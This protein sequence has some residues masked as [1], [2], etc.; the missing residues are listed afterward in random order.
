[1]RDSLKYFGLFSHVGFVVV[2]SILVFVWLGVW[3]DGKVSGSKGAFTVAGIFVGLFAAGYNS[4]RIFQKFL[5]E[6][7]K[8]D[9]KRQ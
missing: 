7:K 8:D 5:D 4:Y 1:M 2:I 9:K 6:T 3:A